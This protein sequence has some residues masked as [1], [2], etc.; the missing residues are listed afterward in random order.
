MSQRQVSFDVL[1]ILKISFF[2]F[3][4]QQAENG[5]PSTEEAYN[6]FTFNFEPEPPYRPEK[7][8]M[9]RQKPKKK[10]KKARDEGEDGNE[11]EDAEDEE[12]SQDEN[13][14]QVTLEMLCFFMKCRSTTPLTP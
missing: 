7:I 1:V 4:L 14:D 8:V 3:F 10:A 5:P 12:D 13:E 9:K 11:Q 6:F 2:F